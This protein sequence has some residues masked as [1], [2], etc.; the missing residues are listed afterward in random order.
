MLRNRVPFG[1]KVPQVPESILC[2]VGSS[3]VAA[4]SV[5]KVQRLT[6]LR[7]FRLRLSGS[8]WPTP[9]PWYSLKSIGKCGRNTDESPRIE[10]ISGG[11]NRVLVLHTKDSDMTFVIPPGVSEHEWLAQES[12]RSSNATEN[13]N[14]REP[15]GLDRALLARLLTGEWIRA[16]QNV[17][18][19][20]PTGLGK[21][22]L[23]CALVNQACRQ[24]FS[25]SYLRMPK[26]NE[27]MAIAHGTPAGYGDKRD[28]RDAG[29]TLRR[30]MSTR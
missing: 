28:S 13:I 11:R 19:V 20:A 7:R 22:W 25:A 15:R 2:N 8:C 1:R 12:S 30:P 17:I 3:N 18:L 5:S 16:H 4:V 6:R 27:E 24:G 29:F 21:S 9:E 23:A 10:R 14:Y 26:F